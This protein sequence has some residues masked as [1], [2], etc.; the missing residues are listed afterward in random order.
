[1]FGRVLNTI[2]HYTR[3]RLKDKGLND[4]VSWYWETKFADM[5]H[6]ANKLYS[7]LLMILDSVNILRRTSLHKENSCIFLSA[8]SE[9]KLKYTCFSLAFPVQV[10][11]T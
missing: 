3:R 6:F 1:M 9:K 7:P 2:L 8:T 4:F 11:Q 10:N 5:Y